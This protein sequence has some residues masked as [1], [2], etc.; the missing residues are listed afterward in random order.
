ML[1][2]EF[3]VFSALCKAK[4]SLPVTWENVTDYTA[5]PSPVKLRSYF[6]SSLTPLFTK[7]RLSEIGIGSILLFVAAF[8][9]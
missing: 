4:T 7:Q 6:S 1:P 9:L 8:T 2:P 5:Q 3:G